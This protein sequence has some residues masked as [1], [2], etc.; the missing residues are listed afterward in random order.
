MAEATPED[1]VIFVGVSLVLGIA[2]R[3]LLH[4]TRVPYTVALLI[5]GIAMG[6]L[7]YGTASG[8]GKLGAGVRLWANINPNLLLSVFLPALLFESSFSMEIHQIKKCMVQMLLL[9]GPGVL[10]ST[11]ALGAALKVT[12]PYNWDWKTSLLL[13]GLLSATDPVAVVALLKELGASKKLSTIIEGESL[14]NDGTAIVVYQLFYQMVMGQSF[15]AGDVIKFL[16]QVSL[17][18]VAVG[19]AFGIV[20]VLWLGFIFN[21]TVIEITLTLAVSY[22]A[23]FTAQDA[24]EV[25]GVL[26]VMTL[27]MFYA[28]FART[29]FKGDSQ[30][31]LHH[32]W[33]MVAYIANTLIFILSGV[34]IADGVLHNDNH[35]ERHGSSW[36]Y[37]LLL[38]V[39]VLV[40]RALVVTVLFPLLKQFGYGLDWKESIILTWSGLR[41]A[42]ALALSL[43]VKRASDTAGQSYLKP[44]VGTL[45]VFFTGG[46]VFLT[47]IVNGSTTQLF[48]HWLGMDRLSS[49]KIR[50]LNY[51]KYEM[52]K[53][54][55]DRF[56]ELGDDQELGPAEWPT[57]KKYITC[58]NNLEGEEASH[59]HEGID[60]DHDLHSMNLKD[61]RVRLL[62]GVQAAYWVMLEEGR[63][64][65]HIAD[66]L[67][68]S[69]DEAMDHVSTQPLNDWKGLQSAVHFPTHYRF[70]QLSRLPPRIVTIIT[71]KRL[72]TGCCVSAAFLRAHRIARTQLNEFIGGS[73]IAKK[74]ISESEEEGEEAEKFL[75]DVRVTFPQVLRV[76]KTRQVT[77]SVLQHLS[78][79][80]Q[81]LEKTGLLEEKEMV[82]LDDALQRDLKRLHRN[83]PIVKMPKIRELLRAHPL[84]GALPQDLREPLES[85]T[86]ETM[87]LR[88]VSLYKE[89]SRPNGIW[90]ISVGAVKWRSRNLSSKHSLNPVFSH[91]ST[92]GLYEV[93]IGKPYIC[94]M[95]TDS[96]VHCFFIDADK[97]QNLCRADPDI[98]GFLW[99]ESS[100]VIAKLLL[101]EVFENLA[102][103]KLRALVAERSIMNVHIKGEVINV[104]SNYIGILLEGF[105][106]QTESKSLVTP[107]AVL[108]PS[109]TDLGVDTSALSNSKL[110]YVGP[111]YQVEARA[112]VIFFDVT[113]LETD[114]HPLHRPASLL[115]QVELPRHHSNR[116]HSGLLSWPESFYKARGASPGDV[117]IQQMGPTFS[118]RALQ[119]SMYGSMIDDMHGGTGKKYLTQ[120][121]MPRL[122]SSTTDSHSKSYPRVP[123]RTE[124][125]TRTLTK[126]QSE[127]GESLRSRVLNRA[128]SGPSNTVPPLPVRRERENEKEEESDDDEEEEVIV[129][130]DSPS[131]LTFHQPS[132]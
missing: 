89:D 95:V 82:H 7:E 118:A 81:N 124:S 10:I 111:A 36:G 104:T 55:L 2:S 20:S 105:V 96:A 119:L 131:T 66:I 128:G 16:S 84:L 87:K 53:R 35:F 52:L 125:A 65:Q 68:P 106:T 122:G 57:V 46:I 22:I 97:I 48:L 73:D 110:C 38:Y 88:G 76:V 45:F 127:G 58:L 129:R 75:E 86:K 108:L 5:L 54:A 63:I 31:S 74:V 70:L 72:E 117:E 121:G 51:T 61:I 67:I 69:V 42:V 80:V 114:H 99:Q 59:P 6:S 120:K 50:I 78:E 23:F 113:N 21:D 102:M 13:G 85:S 115:S 12:F 92:L 26:T 56:G 14:M 37:L 4:G 123:S 103:T 107:P 79:Y 132:K 101:P 32:F 64:S 28:A 47:L 77:Y 91:S 83:P 11:F 43:S 93:L 34:V 90:L 30:Q 109:D 71:V 98:E 1:A 25:S 130:I 15:S 29:A 60:N 40:S 41:G 24:A 44:E 49:A 17:G 18:A 62:N 116:E 8:L 112:R 27:G 100:I 33:E 9:A 19:L 3:H 39:F 94:D 126:V